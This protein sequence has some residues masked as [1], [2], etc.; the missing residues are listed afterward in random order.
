MSISSWLLSIAG[1]VVIGALIDVLLTESPTS[2]FIK[3]IFGFFAL[4]VIVQ[5]LP[6][7]LQS[8]ADLASGKVV[9]NT[10]LLQNINSQTARAFEHNT[11]TA[12]EIANF[13]NIIITID[14]DKNATSFKITKV[15]VNALGAN[16]I[17][18]EKDV[19]KIVCAVCS[20]KEDI[21]FYVG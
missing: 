17:D 18:I 21:I 13:E 1:I 14:Y 3:G 5:P 2:K 9:L 11:Q 19:V 4:F 6:A 8:G 10:E 16:G 12:L 20:V 7:L 15:Y